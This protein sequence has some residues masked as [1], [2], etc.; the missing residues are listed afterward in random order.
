M[1]RI[2]VQS[3]LNV[4]LSFAFHES[5]GA[6][7]ET[8]FSHEFGQRYRL[9]MKTILVEKS[10]PQSSGGP[11][12]RGVFRLFRE[13]FCIGR[14]AERNARSTF[15]PSVSHKRKDHG[16]VTYRIAENS[17]FSKFSK[18][19]LSVQASSMMSQLGFS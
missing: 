2:F 1:I 6:D 10:S 5:A 18:A 16:F 3:K 8:A 4:K 13:T 17:Y 11:L 19:A 15:C 9:P 12:F 7:K 14:C